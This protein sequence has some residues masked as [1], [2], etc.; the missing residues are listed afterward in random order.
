MKGEIS[1]EN[2][3]QEQQP[4]YIKLDYD[5]E[6]PEEGVA[7]VKKVIDSTPSERLTSY[8]IEQ[9][10]KYILKLDTIEERK[11]ERSI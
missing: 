5:L 2:E 9:M 3:K 8:Y 4:N 11:Q 1:M 6:E 10:I 7:L